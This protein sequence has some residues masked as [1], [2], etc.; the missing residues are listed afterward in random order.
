MIK[1]ANEQLVTHIC[2]VNSDQEKYGN[3]I[4]GLNSQKALNNDQFPKTMVD[5]NN[6]LSTH[7]FDNAKAHKNNN[8]NNGNK[9][10]KH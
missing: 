6:A 2:L 7:I 4:K 5:G 1:L 10:N 9:H 3:I 8:H